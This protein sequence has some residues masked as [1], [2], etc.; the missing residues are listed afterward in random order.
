V[1]GCCRTAAGSPGPGGRPADLRCAM[2]LQFDSPRDDPS[3]LIKSAIQ[4][5]SRAM[6][7]LQSN[8]AW[9]PGA[10]AEQRG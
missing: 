8:A 9:H 1:S 6:A 5:C 3:D 7:M 4:H 2:N 10:S